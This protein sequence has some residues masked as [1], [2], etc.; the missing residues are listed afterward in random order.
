MIEF[1]QEYMPAYASIFHFIF[2]GL[3]LVVAKLI[4]EKVPY[5]NKII[6]PSALLAGGLGWLVSDQFL[7]WI[8]YDVPLLEEV[9]YHAI[10]LGFIALALRESQKGPYKPFVTGAIIASGYIFQ[11]LLGVLVVGFLFSEYFL[12]TGFLVALGFSQGPSLAFNIGSGWESQGLLPLGGGLGVSIAAIGFLW[13]G[14]LGVVIN[15]YHARK[16]NLPILY[17][18]DR[19]ETESIE[20]HTHTKL[21]LYDALTTNAVVV[22][23]IYG[24]VFL[25]LAFTE[26]V[27]VPMGGIAST[28]AGLFYGLNFLI[29]VLI[30]FGYKRIRSMVRRRGVNL[31]FINN[32][33]VLQSISNFFFNIMITASVLIISRSS[34]SEYIGFI[35]IATTIAG[36]SSYYYFKA[37]VNWQ[38]SEF[39]HEFTIGIYGNNTGV[40]STGIALVKMIDPDFKTPVAQSLVVSGGTGLLFAIPLFGI[41]IIPES[42]LDQ[43]QLAFIYTLIGL[44]GYWL[45]L[46]TYLF[47]SKRRAYES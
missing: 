8:S 37:L 13:G 32:N 26:S 30:A 21:S 36:I 44:V 27:L 39:Q 29:G 31:D 14:I 6:I 15:N 2:I 24:L 4:K 45:V 1:I 22:L 42:F 19:I 11:A 35:L 12:G 47:I 18:E 7:G 38:Y 23:L 41:L 46:M 33:F 34:V 43:P 16:N 9:V 28:L 5:L 20:L 17:V 25:V 10:G 40:I 3:L